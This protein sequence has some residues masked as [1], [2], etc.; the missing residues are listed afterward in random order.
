[1]DKSELEKTKLALETFQCFF[2]QF[3]SDQYSRVLLEVLFEELFTK[4][5]TPLHL[6][7]TERQDRSESGSDNEGNSKDEQI[8]ESVKPEST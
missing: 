3:G 1:M 7:S 8:N 6:L 5:R 2:D 4:D